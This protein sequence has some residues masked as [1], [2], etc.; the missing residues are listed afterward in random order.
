ML[1]STQVDEQAHFTPNRA[2]ENKRNVPKKLRIPPLDC[3]LFSLLFPLGARTA[4]E[5]LGRSRRIRGRGQNPGLISTMGSKVI[6]STSPTASCFAKAGSRSLQQNCQANCTVKRS[7][8]TLQYMPL[9]DHPNPAGQHQ[10]DKP[11][12]LSKNHKHAGAES[13]F[14]QA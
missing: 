10:S 1:V 13:T 7:F 3:L 14:P 12:A 11:A 2:T 5:P 4:V 8:L 6:G 9:L